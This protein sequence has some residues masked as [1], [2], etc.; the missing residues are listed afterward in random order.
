MSRRTRR[1]FVPATFAAAWAQ[2]RERASASVG[3]QS[4]VCATSRTRWS[5]QLAVVRSAEVPSAEARGPEVEGRQREELAAEILASEVPI[6]KRRERPC[7]QPQ[8]RDQAPADDSLAGRL[9]GGVAKPG[10]DRDL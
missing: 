9:A 1:Y 8:G 7:R 3:T 2:R 6:D 5:A 4:I 10:V